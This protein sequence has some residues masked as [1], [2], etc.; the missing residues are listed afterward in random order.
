MNVLLTRGKEQNSMLSVASAVKSKRAE[1]GKE[2]VI[3]IDNGDLYQGTPV[4]QVQLF[5][6]AGG[7]QML[8]SPWQS[9]IAR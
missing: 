9:A 3:L 6:Y 7:I 2:K 4:S 8:R 1:L 5:D